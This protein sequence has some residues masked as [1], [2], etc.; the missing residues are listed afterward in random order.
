MSEPIS[1]PV[2][3]ITAS[4]DRFPMESGES[5]LGDQEYLSIRSQPNDPQMPPDDSTSKHEEKSITV[6]SISGELELRMEPTD[7]LQPPDQHDRRSVTIY[8]QLRMRDLVVMAFGSFY[9]LLVL[10]FLWFLWN[11]QDNIPFWRWLVLKSYVQSTVTFSSAILRTIIGAQ[12]SL[13]TSMLAA[14]IM[15]TLGFS[16]KQSPFLSIQRS[17]GGLPFNLLGRR[18]FLGHAKVIS[19]LTILLSFTTI[20][21]YLTS[22]ALIADFKVISTP[23]YPVDGQTLYSISDMALLGD[24]PVYTSYRPAN[25]PAFAEYSEPAVVN[26]SEQETDDTGP[27]LRAILPIS[28]TSTRESLS[29]YSGYATLLN[30]HIVCVK[31]LI[32]NLTFESRQEY[33]G[34]R[35]K[36]LISGRISLG[37]V[38]SGIMFD[39]DAAGDFVTQ[40]PYVSTPRGPTQP[41]T[42]ICQLAPSRLIPD[43]WPISMCVAGNRLNYTNYFLDEGRLN[44]LGTRATSLLNEVILLDPLSYVMVNYSG[45]PPQSNSNLTTFRIDGNNWTEIEGDSPTWRTFEVPSTYPSFTSISIS[46]CFSHFV[47]IDAAISANSSTPRIEPK[48]SKSNTSYALDASQVVR[49]LG[50]DGVKRSLNDRGILSL[51]WSSFW[52]AGTATAT[53]TGLDGTYGFGMQANSFT[54]P[55]LGPPLDIHSYI[56]DYEGSSVSATWGLCTNCMNNI[57]DDNT[58]GI[59]SA[60]S[61][62]FQTSIINSGSVAT[63]LQALFTVVNMMQ[64]YDR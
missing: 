58:F 10:G 46:Y 39:P 48:L 62:I 34:A 56:S 35:F 5:E 11:G 26:S 3:P 47:G 12:S 50:A 41:I 32:Q 14:I 49:Q 61:S 9:T 36:P 22:T 13:A 57:T 23:G 1:E 21:A 42:F 40:L 6:Q 16:L 44:I 54:P 17:N 28:S 20:A 24:E 8:D 59:H 27:T 60:L 63:A 33:G 45:V 30:S 43:E 25:F 2:S 55:F 64:Y 18:Y 51:Q 29:N 15:E 37:K 52:S 31:P 19:F 7:P 53:T 4:G 38:P